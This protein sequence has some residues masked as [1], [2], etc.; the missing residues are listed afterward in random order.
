MAPEDPWL[1]RLGRLAALEELRLEEIAGIIHDGPL[2]AVAAA[3]MR[4]QLLRRTMT[5]AADIRACEDIG[6]TLHAGILGLRRVLAELGVPRPGRDGIVSALGDYLEQA[7]SDTGIR[8]TLD[9]EAALGPHPIAYRLAQVGLV[10]LRGQPGVASIAVAAGRAG[11]G[12]TVH[13]Q[14]GAPVA[15]GPW[16]ATM[17]ERASVAGG[18]CRVDGQAGPPPTVAAVEFWLPW[19]GAEA[20][21]G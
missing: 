8:F 13:L 6:A 21:Q 16:L 19:S 18:W 5:S 4:L 11:G 15:P 1:G 17:E 2:Q 10:G 20:G 9:G 14:P 12:L 7:E 3:Y